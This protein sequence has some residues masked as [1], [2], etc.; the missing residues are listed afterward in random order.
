MADLIKSLLRL[1]KQLFLFQITVLDKKLTKAT[2]QR[3]NNR[4]RRKIRSL[5]ETL[6]SATYFL[7]LKNVLEGF[8][9]LQQFTL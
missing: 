5:T 1:A 9:I 4:F 2:K 8:A 7:N 3:V 6:W